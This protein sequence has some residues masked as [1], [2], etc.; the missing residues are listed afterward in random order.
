[1]A[2]GRG[3]WVQTTHRVGEVGRVPLSPNPLLSQI[4][5]PFATILAC[6]PLEM[7][8]QGSIFTHLLHHYRAGGV[9]GEGLSP[10]PSAANLGRV[11]RA[12]LATEG[13]PDSPHPLSFL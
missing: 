9:D 2:I 3:L 5:G 11:R 1:M 4:Q 7:L 12:W 6:L 8:G 10:L 13:A